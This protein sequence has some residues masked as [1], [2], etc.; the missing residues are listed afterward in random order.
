M[1]SKSK[2]TH[3]VAGPPRVDCDCTYACLFVTPVCYQ[4]IAGG[5]ECQVAPLPN[6]TAGHAPGTVV[7]HMR[8]PQG[9]RLVAYSSNGGATWGPSK[10]VLV[11]GRSKYGGGTC[12]GSTIA[13]GGRLLFSTPFHPTS[14]ANMTVLSS[15]DGGLTYEASHLPL[16]HLY[17]VVQ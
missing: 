7:I 2:T 9:Q 4:A 1:G 10:V 14:R 12:E 5:N 6:G 16:T 11:G 17:I 8:T 13:A 3:N 15:S